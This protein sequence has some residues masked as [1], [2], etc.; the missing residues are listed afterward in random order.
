[1]PIT[2][3]RILAVSQAAKVCLDNLVKIEEDYRELNLKLLSGENSAEETW[4]MLGGTIE[5]H[6]PQLA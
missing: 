1:M 5:T 3:D 4:I 6:K 2:Q